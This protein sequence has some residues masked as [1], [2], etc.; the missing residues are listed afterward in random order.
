M[1]RFGLV[2]FADE[3][4]KVADLGSFVGPGGAA[5]QAKIDAKLAPFKPLTPPPMQRPSAFPPKPAPPPMTNSQ[6]DQKIQDTGAAMRN[7][8]Q[9]GRASGQ[10]GD[11]PL[12]KTPRT[13][14]GVRG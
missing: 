7:K 5:A 8:I 10:I 14:F 6:I 13:V 3:L 4:C 9:A 1:R 12:I 11:V 2:S